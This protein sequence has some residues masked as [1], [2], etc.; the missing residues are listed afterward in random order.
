MASGRDQDVAG[1]LLPTE[2]SNTTDLREREKRDALERNRIYLPPS[3]RGHQLSLPSRRRREPL[4]SPRDLHFSWFHARFSRT[5]GNRVPARAR[6]EIVLCDDVRVRKA[7]YS[8]RTP[9]EE[10]A[11]TAGRIGSSAY[12]VVRGDCLFQNPILTTRPLSVA[13]QPEQSISR[14]GYVRYLILCWQRTPLLPDQTSPTT[15]SDACSRHIR[16]SR[17]RHQRDGGVDRCPRSSCGGLSF[18]I[19]QPRTRKW[20]PY[21]DMEFS[22]LFRSYPIISSGPT[23]GSFEARLPGHFQR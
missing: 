4:P 21:T 14:S 3:S 20:L 1:H 5:G 16:V 7:P 10:R 15:A 8:E 23:H 17:S 11:C 9:A 18:F 6:R 13:L 12:S 19:H 2:N 22:K